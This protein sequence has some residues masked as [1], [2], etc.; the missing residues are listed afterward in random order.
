M[1][2]IPLLLLVLLDSSLRPWAELLVP[3]AA[4]VA[5]TSTHT[6]VFSFDGR[7]AA[8]GAGRSGANAVSISLW[9]WRARWQPAATAPRALVSARRGGPSISWLGSDGQLQFCARPGRCVAS[10]QAVGLA[11]WAFVRLHLCGDGALRGHVGGV[12]VAQLAAV[13]HLAGGSVFFSQLAVGGGGELAG[14]RRTTA[15]A[16]AVLVAGIAVSFAGTGGE[17]GGD[18][19]TGIPPGAVP[20][21]LVPPDAESRDSARALFTAGVH[22]GLSAEPGRAHTSFALSVA[23][24][25]GHL[26]PSEL[27][28]H[29]AL[30]HSHL[31]G[32]ASSADDGAGV[33]RRQEVAAAYLSAAAEGAIGAGGA[34]R[35][36]ERVVLSREEEQATPFL[37]HKGEDDELYALLED[38]ARRGD[39]AAM[40]RL[41]HMHGAAVG[42]ITVKNL[43]LA[44]Q[45]YANSAAAG[46]A[47]G[48][49]NLGLS[50]HH[51]LGGSSRDAAKA[52]KLFEQSSRLGYGPASN[53]LG[54]MKHKG[55]DEE[56]AL[57]LFERA[58]EAGMCDA[59][60]NAAQ[61]HISG[62]FG[63]R[64]KNLTRAAQLLELAAAQSHPRSML[65][66][67]RM[68]LGDANGTARSWDRG[69]DLLHRVAH[70]ASSWNQ[71][72]VEGLSIYLKGANRTRAAA[73]AVDAPGSS[74]WM[75]RQTGPFTYQ[76]FAA[77]AT[78]RALHPRIEHV[79]SIAKYEVA[80]TLGCA[81][82]AANAAFLYRR[83]ATGLAG[84]GHHRLREYLLLRA[85]E[86]YRQLALSPRASAEALRIIGEMHLDQ[87]DGRFGEGSN[88]TTTTAAAA[89]ASFQGA[90]AQGDNEAQFKVAYML[91]RGLGTAPDRE[92]A[93]TLYRELQ[94]AG[95]KASVAATL[96]LAGLTLCQYFPCSKDW[97]PV[98]AGTL[99]GR[100]HLRP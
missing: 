64:E 79:S 95:G 30:A 35:W 81:D 97:A 42:G 9:V 93:K 69:L 96:A 28:A 16:S 68:K 82:G 29:G 52:A 57:A 23:F 44:V 76:A 12:L 38:K 56:G 21:W 7:G 24:A 3:S 75:P 40:N 48:M 49:Y 2:L 72:H 74:S 25:S 34:H 11:Q 26:G 46:S 100:R 62:R 33:R 47:E 37:G 32:F 50:F 89:F 67:A 15:P 65:S 94:N 77:H 20:P 27:Q 66:L 71:Y 17:D 55:G 59:A 87:L 78:L 85:H 14:G 86:R 91:Q 10:A 90:A 51:G 61:A 88:G 53:G 80:A 1:R 4:P 22:L 36:S 63:A 41:A 31:R 13:L 60:F 6:F 43:S 54:L 19:G 92:R 45:L 58:A 39:A 99:S 73:G 8:G 5:V 70:S 83:A 84:G 98:S 18:G